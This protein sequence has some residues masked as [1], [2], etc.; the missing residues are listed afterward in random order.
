VYENDQNG[1]MFVYETG[2]PDHPRYVINFPTKGHWRAN[3]KLSDILAGLADLR[4]VILDRR[5]RSIA[6]PP[7]G[8]GNG[9][10]PYGV[11][12]LATVHWTAT[13]EA[14]RKGTDP[15]TLTGIIREWNR[16]KERLF[17]EDHVR[18]AMEHL[19]ELSWVAS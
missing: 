19:D 5:I 10:S 14:S 16:R 7:L 18:V 4:Q 3:S 11:E 2:T 13:R 12:L 1:R 17:T 15:A 9:G 8:C 6:V